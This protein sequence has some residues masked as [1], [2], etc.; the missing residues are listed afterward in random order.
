MEPQIGLKREQIAELCRRHQVRR[1][2]LFGS[3]AR[4]D[5][6]PKRSDLDFLVEFQPLAPGTYART[7]FGLLE[8]L[9]Q[10]FGRRVDLVEAGSV[11][12]PYIRQEIETWQETLYAA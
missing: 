5:F 6:D 1:L 7:Y 2:A 4:Q 11:R 9:Q 3:A 10:L 12:N 8:A